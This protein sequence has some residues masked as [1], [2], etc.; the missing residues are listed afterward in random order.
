MLGV[1][2]VALYG[3]L[4]WLSFAFVYGQGHAQRPIVLFV[5]VYAGIFICYGLA[6]YPLLGRAVRAPR[7]T[8]VA[9]VMM[10][11]LLFRAT[12]FFSQP[13]Q[14]DDFYR[15]LWDGAV[16]AEGLNPYR[17]A[18]LRVQQQTD[19]GTAG[20]ALRA[21]VQLAE[22]DGRL[23]FVLSRVNHP[24]ISTVYPPFAQA[25]F[26][27]A[28]WLAPGS[29][30]VLRL[31]FVAFDLGVCALLLILL[32]HL[33]LSPLLLVVYA[34][35]PLIIKET[36]NS[37]H[38]DVVPA[39]CVVLA[40]VLMVKGRDVLAHISLAVAVLGKLYPVLL[41]P[42]F[43]A[44]VWKAHGW[45]RA[46]LG[47]AAVAAVLLVGY[48]PFWPAGR[49]L[50]IGTYTFA[51]Q[52]QTNSLL[53]PGIVALVGERWLANGVVG[54]GLAGAA[55]LVGS[56]SALEDD[57]QFVWSNGLLLGLLFLLSPVANP[58]YFVGLVPF[59]SIFPL[60]SWLLLS[61]LLSLY[62]V[63]FYFLY[64]GRLETFHVWLEYVPFYGMLAWEWWQGEYGKGRHGV[65]NELDEEHTARVALRSADGSDTVRTGRLGTGG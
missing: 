41:L 31:V 22:R 14:E 10:F 64:R 4:T 2:T 27:L 39:C 11:G 54:L 59:L 29:L 45:G 37:A 15:Y 26:G 65:G 60:R 7:S 58:W 24:H 32:K 13:I 47:L 30:S 6:V 40:V 43:L 35:S 51:E 50:W 16:V 38:Y 34:W 56:R 8:A 21:Y 9:L 17:F 55:F 42:V 62:Y 49:A 23:S 61:G 36:M 5:A 19:T 20:A 18:P 12:L 63:S 3:L 46:L 25:I 57:H 28:A 48:A 1:G 44:R 53:F 52:W 33:G